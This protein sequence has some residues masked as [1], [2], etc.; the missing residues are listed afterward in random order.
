[1]AR[2]LEPSAHDLESGVVELRELAVEMGVSPDE[3]KSLADAPALFG[4]IM[5]RLLLGDEELSE[6]GEAVRE[7]GLDERNARRTWVAIGGADPSAADVFVS[8]AEVEALA[9]VDAAQSLVGASAATAIAWSFRSA[10][11][12]LADT[13]VS[14]MQFSFDWPRGA[15]RTPRS[16]LANFYKPFV[17]EMIPWMGRALEAIMR[18]KLADRIPYDWPTE[19]EGLPEHREVVCVIRFTK[20]EV[21]D[22]VGVLERV[23]AEIERATAP[24]IRFQGFLGKGLL[25]TV[26]SPAAAG[27]AVRTLT[28]SPSIASQDPAC[29]V[30]FGRVSRRRGRPF[31]PVVSTAGRLAALAAPGTILANEAL[32]E[33]DTSGW[34]HTGIEVFAGSDGK[35]A[36]YKLT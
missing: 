8:K 14:S 6:F 15:G 12:E 16:D 3:A 1:M 22:P 17:G 7:A 25:A 26:A 23:P 36:V 33:R 35:A 5:D 32:V 11:D 27:S 28:M 4:A 34:E 9:L 18:R 10:L 29:G 30:S 31:G 21:E 19:D 24:A 2:G 13:L 20:S